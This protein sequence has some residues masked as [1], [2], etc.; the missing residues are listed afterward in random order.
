MIAS[1]NKLELISREFCHDTDNDMVDEEEERETNDKDF[2]GFKKLDLRDEDIE[3]IKVYEEP[4]EQRWRFIPLFK[5][6]AINKWRMWQIGFDGISNLEIINCYCDTG[7]KVTPLFTPVEP[8]D[9]RTMFEQALLQARHRYKEKIHNG[10]T[11]SCSL[12]RPMPQG[13][14]ANK[15]KEGMI[16]KWPVATQA[17][18]DG[19]RFM[20]YN[21]NGEL[22]GLTYAN[23]EYNHLDH[24]MNEI[25]D[26]LIYLPEN[27]VLDGEL[28]K[29]GFKFQ[30][31]S[32]I[33]RRVV[34]LHEKRDEI[35]FHIY[36][37]NYTTESGK[38]T[39]DERYN[40]LIEAYKKY[41]EDGNV[42][43]KFFILSSNL[44]YSHED[45]VE[46]HNFYL[47]LGY[48]GTIIKKIAYL[49]SSEAERESACYKKG[50]CNNILKYKDFF[51]EEGIIIDVE[52]AKGTEQGCAVFKVQDIRGNI[53]GLRMAETFE[54][55][56]EYLQN[57]DKVI[58][59]EIT[60]KYQTLSPYGVPIFPVGKAIRDYEGPDFETKVVK[61]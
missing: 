56:R 23:N 28:Y 37:L 51:E 61:E 27:T 55:R 38:P 39:F 47:S 41:L 60:Y 33:V 34:N 7:K 43:T 50:R 1:F 20:I 32:S 48:E 52:E 54:Q 24:I 35:E 9:G 12:D 17:K 4:K 57:K 5:L 25:R 31:I 49:G 16:K 59:K 53:F 58:G 21:N 8:K 19:I 45:I 30:Q 2:I 26:F 13:M 10:Y 18:L 14:K 22:S 36:D 11:P 40:T 6:S 42:N 44:A 3:E 46:Q 29:H 15:Y